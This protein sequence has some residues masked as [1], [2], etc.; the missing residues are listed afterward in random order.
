MVDAGILV[1]L[2]GVVGAAATVVSALPR[3]TL[4]R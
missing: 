3:G 4:R 2:A 1:M